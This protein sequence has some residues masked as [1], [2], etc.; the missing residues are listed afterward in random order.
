MV[1]VLTMSRNLGHYL[2][3]F[4]PHHIPTVSCKAE[5][6]KCSEDIFC[7]VLVTS[8]QRGSYECFIWNRSQMKEQ[9][10]IP[11]FTHTSHPHRNAGQI[12]DTSVK[13]GHSMA[14]GCG[15]ETQ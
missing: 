2:P 4:L 11:H 8:V 12:L 5:V 14:F 6:L 10:F 13:R 7:K 1:L 9:R 15:A 3:V